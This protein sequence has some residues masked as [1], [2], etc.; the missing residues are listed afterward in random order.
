MNETQ[1]S[2]ASEE[3]NKS[4]YLSSHA[5]NEA[6]EKLE[7]R[8]CDEPGAGGASHRYE[9][10]GF[11]TT[12]NP[13][14]DCGLPPGDGLIVLFQNGPIKE[15]GVNGVTNESLLA[16]VEDRLTGFQ[17]GPYA[18]FENAE[19]LRCVQRALGYLHGRTHARI[20]RGVE[21]TQTV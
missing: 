19:A 13:S 18:C 6:N 11:Y 8:V 17:S 14:G 15:V 5:L 2:A 4:R 12:T 1:V 10:A 7:I 16:I 9:I 21:G 20:D 3:P